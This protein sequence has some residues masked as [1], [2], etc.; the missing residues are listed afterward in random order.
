M[1]EVTDEFDVIDTLITEVG[2]I[3]V[4]TEAF[5]VLHSFERTLRGGDIEG[6]FGWVNFES[7]IHV[8]F[9]KR[10]KDGSETFSKIL[11]TVVVKAWLVGGKA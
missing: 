8:F 3:V 2:R 7:E 5:V 11:E 9:V 1:T 6:N 10:I 4:E